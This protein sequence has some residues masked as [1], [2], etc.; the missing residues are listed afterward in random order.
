MVIKN[1]PNPMGI[2]IPSGCFN[3][4]GFAKNTTSDGPNFETTI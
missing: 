4:F 3:I 1:F 2:K